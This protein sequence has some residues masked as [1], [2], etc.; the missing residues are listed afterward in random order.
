MESRP[1][2][3]VAGKL[4]QQKNCLKFEGLKQSVELNNLLVIKIPKMSIHNVWKSEQSLISD[5]T[6]PKL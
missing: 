1:E 6:P 5:Q 2:A 3:E 4:R